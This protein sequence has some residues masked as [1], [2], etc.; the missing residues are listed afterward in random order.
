M[1]VCNVEYFSFVFFSLRIIYGTF[2]QRDTILL[3]FPAA[4]SAVPT[5]T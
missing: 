5:A 1:A 2:S 3:V 4:T